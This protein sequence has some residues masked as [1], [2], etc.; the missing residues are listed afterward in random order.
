MKT[1]IAIL[2]AA[3]LLEGTSYLMLLFIAMPLKYVFG[4]PFAVQLIGSAHGGLFV[5]YVMVALWASRKL[6][7]PMRRLATVIL[8]AILP[9]GPFVIDRSL[10]REAQTPTTPG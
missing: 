10:Q 8:A 5:I 7:W 6:A 9:F 1:T 4:Q 3:G 2:R